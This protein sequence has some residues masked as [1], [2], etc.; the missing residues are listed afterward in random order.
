MKPGS[1]CKVQM[2][3][4]MDQRGVAAFDGPTDTLVAGRL[5]GPK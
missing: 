5:G 3:V 2:T 1:P 4:K